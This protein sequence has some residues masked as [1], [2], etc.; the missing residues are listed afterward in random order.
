VTETPAASSALQLG[1]ALAGGV[2]FAASLGYFVWVWF[3][4]FGRVEGP[5]LAAAGWPPLAI[6]AGLFT[7]FAL[8]HSWLARAGLKARVRSLVSPALERSVYVW[9]ASLLF[10][11]VCRWWQP[12]PGVLWSAGLPIAGVLTALQ[13]GGLVL[14]GVA[15]RRMDVLEL[16]G[17]RQVLPSHPAPPRLLTDGVYRW[18]RHPIYFGW[19]LVVWS[20]PVM[21]GTRAAFAAISTAYLALAILFEE[22]DLERTFGP[23]YAAYR[24]RVRWRMVPFVY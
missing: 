9:V 18:V 5:W 23:A 15:A 20:T 22:A 17:V 8:H 4:G 11:V 21:T 10:V 1:V 7:V 12:V 2:L 14:T 3:F 13:V 24:R 16:A 6:D 19:V